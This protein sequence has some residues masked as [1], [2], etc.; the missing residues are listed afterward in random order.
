MC[1]CTLGLYLQ[2]LESLA[3]IFVADTVGLPL[4]KFVQWAPKDASFLQQNAFWPFKVVQGQGHPRSMILVPIES[5]YMR[6]PI[7]PSLWLWSYLAPFL[8]DGDLLAR[9]CVFFYP[10]LIRRPRSLCSLWNFALKLTM[11]KL[12]S[13]SYPPVKT[14]W[15]YLSHIDKVPACDGQTDRQTDRRTD[16]L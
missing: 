4:F 10:S 13:W 1:A 15:S 6:L 2:K 7:S 3:Y 5:A 14:P 16:L 11:R 8:R 9:N 12:E